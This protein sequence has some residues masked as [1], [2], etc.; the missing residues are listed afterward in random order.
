MVSSRKR[1]T[2]GKSRAST[3]APGALSRV[4]PSLPSAD[5]SRRSIRSPSGSAATNRQS[6][7]AS[8]DDDDDA[9]E[10][11]SST[12]EDGDYIQNK[13]HHK[14]RPRGAAAK[15]S[16]RD[17]ELPRVSSRNGKALPNYDE[18]EMFSGISDSDE[19]EWE[20]EASGY[21][22]EQRASAAL[23]L[24]LSSSCPISPSL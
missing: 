6:R 24:S 4:S 19:E 1:T 17:F 8:E 13:K 16:V 23:S 2:K 20:Y 18:S 21:E 15:R 3:S 22:Q 5:R 7:N 9:S 12:D 14:K 11:S 10:E